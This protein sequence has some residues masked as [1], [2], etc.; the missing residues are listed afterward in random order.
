MGSCSRPQL[1][2]SKLPVGNK[3]LRTH[4]VPKAPI[5]CAHISWLLFQ[6]AISAAS[7]CVQHKSELPVHRTQSPPRVPTQYSRVFT[8]H[9][10]ILK[11]AL[12]QK[13]NLGYEALVN[14]AHKKCCHCAGVGK[15]RQQSNRL[16]NNHLQKK[17]WKKPKVIPF[18]KISGNAGNIAG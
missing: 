7:L 8:K 13:V 10:K 3:A 16:K 17:R 18:S 4:W 12:I 5:C 1:S 9:L 11:A 14:K 2:R 6:L 15:T